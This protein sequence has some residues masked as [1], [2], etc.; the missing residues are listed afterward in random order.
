MSKPIETHI[1]ALELSAKSLKLLQRDM[2]KNHID[3]AHAEPIEI[4]LLENEAALTK[5]LKKM[6]KNY[7]GSLKTRNVVLSIPAEFAFIRTFQLVSE[8]NDVEGQIQWEIEQQGLAGE[9]KL[10]IDW[11][12]LP[13]DAAGE[14][15]GVV[16]AG[17]EENLEEITTESDPPSEERGSVPSARYLVVASETKRLT[18]ILSA[19]KKNKLNVRLCDVDVFALAN[20]FLYSH[21]EAA[22]G[23]F[24]LVDCSG[25][26]ALLCLLDSGRYIDSEIVSGLSFRSAEHALRSARRI[27]ERITVML[28]HHKREPLP[29][30]LCGE[31]LSGQGEATKVLLETLGPDTDKINPF[32]VI[33]VAS[34]LQ[35][36]LNVLA[37][38]FA[39]ATGLTL[40]FPEEGVGT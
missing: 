1:L 11:Y 4:E 14:V 24:M 6:V 17:A 29:L 33:G 3:L 38:A 31:H 26:R 13:A 23:S 10:H 28:T 19:L 2:A 15:S 7:K 12:P 37:P 20:V 30:R 39:V 34:D 5:T 18:P 9:Q 40:R 16:Q 36:Q 21:P 22:T 25:E 27:N 32:A 35:K 8:E